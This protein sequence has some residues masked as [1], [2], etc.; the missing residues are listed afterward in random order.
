[1]KALKYIML[2]FIIAAASF[3]IFK[4]QSY[5][6]LT[7]EEDYLQLLDVAELSE[8]LTVSCCNQLAKSLPDSPVILRVSAV[9]EAEH[10]FWAGRQ[11]VSIQEI[12]AGSGFEAGQ[13]IYVTFSNWSLKLDEDR[14]SI[15]RGFVNVMKSGYD[16]LV[17]ISKRIEALDEAVPVYSLNDDTC[18]APVFCYEDQSNIIAP[19]CGSST[20]VP[21]RQVENNEFFAESEAALIA[22]ENFKAKMLSAFP[23]NQTAFH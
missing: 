13:E 8:G 23:V 10:L 20:Y 2:V 14:N 6:D 15:Q 9:S 22:W 11:K 5:T 21:Y 12:Y 3:G 4:R 17:F 1:M 16:Y 19:T 7:K 18:I